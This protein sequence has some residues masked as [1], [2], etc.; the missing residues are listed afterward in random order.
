MDMLCKYASLD[1]LQLLFSFAL[2][3]NL[4][5]RNQYTPPPK[6]NRRLALIPA[7]PGRGC[8]GAVPDREGET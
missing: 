4:D 6:S 1:F 2:G 7:R 5:V 8:A 3:K